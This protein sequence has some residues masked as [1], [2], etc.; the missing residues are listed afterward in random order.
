MCFSPL[1]D[2]AQKLPVV[3]AHQGNFDCRVKM[4]QRLPHGFP[5]YRENTFSEDYRSA[6]LSLIVVFRAVRID[7]IGSIADR[8]S[9][10]C[11][12]ISADLPDVRYLHLRDREP[13]LVMQVKLMES[14]DEV[15][16]E[17]PSLVRLYQIQHDFFHA[18][19][20]V[21]FFSGFEEIFKMFP[22]WVYRELDLSMRGN[23]VLDSEFVPCEIERGSEAVNRVS[24]EDCE[25]LNNL[26]IGKI[27]HHVLSGLRIYFRGN[28]VRCEVSSEDLG[29]VSVEFI[30][31]FSGP[32]DL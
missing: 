1:S 3:E 21:L 18:E 22:G 20:G 5:L 6:K 32:F 14:V 28:R 24:T 31:V 9:L 17:V 29:S 30:D 15:S 19:D 25:S 23:A 2:V 10:Y 8:S 7:Q 27:L 12:I 26:C 13:V 4:A 16:D 11:A